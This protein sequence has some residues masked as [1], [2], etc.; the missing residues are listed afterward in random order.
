[1]AF[2]KFMPTILLKRESRHQK[3]DTSS[4]DNID[5]VIS[6]QI[7][8][9]DPFIFSS[10]ILIQSGA[11]LSAWC[12]FFFLFSKNPWISAGENTPSGTSPPNFSA[13]VAK[14]DGSHSWWSSL[15]LRE[16]EA[17]YIR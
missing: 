17:S 8:P 5:S 2:S 6:P 10:A 9:H 3:E 13:R 4:N 14:I 12:W 11:S 7:Q 1:M 16:P 15:G